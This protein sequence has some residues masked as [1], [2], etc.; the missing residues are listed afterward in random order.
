LSFIDKYN[1]FIWNS[2][3]S[4]GIERWQK[5]K[6]VKCAVGSVLVWNTT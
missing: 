4:V 2:V 3:V 6:C 1:F 5:N